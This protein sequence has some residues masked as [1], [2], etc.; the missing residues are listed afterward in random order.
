MIKK[1]NI[2]KHLTPDRVYSLIS[3]PTRCW[4]MNPVHAFESRFRQLD[5]QA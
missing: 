4:A 2:Y 5:S 1:I 3:M